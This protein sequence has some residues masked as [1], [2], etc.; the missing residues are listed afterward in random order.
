MRVV[1]LT[2]L[3]DKP[4]YDVFPLRVFSDDL[5]RLGID[6]VFSHSIWERAVSEADVVFVSSYKAKDLLGRGRQGG[7]A[8]EV[9]ERLGERKGKVIWFDSSDAADISQPYVLPNVAIY[10]KAQ[11]W[12]DRQLY[13]KPLYQGQWFKD[14]YHR[15]FGVDE[16]GGEL[17]EPPAPSALEKLALAWNPAFNDWSIVGRG[18]ITR[19]WHILF[20]VPHY[21]IARQVLPLK[22]RPL[23]ISCRVRA[24][25]KEPIVHFHREAI[26]NAVRNL[27]KRRSVRCEGTVSHARY[28]AEMARTRMVASPFGWGEICY[29][30]FECCMAGAVLLKP[31][32]SH[33]QTWPDFYVPEDTYVAHAWDLADF[34][35]KVDRVLQRVEESQGIADRGRTRLLD[36]LCSSA[37]GRKF[38]ERFAGL[39]DRALRS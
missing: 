23:D 29:R 39:V 36:A 18:R 13:S 38:A 33:L 28:L 24:W 30:D 14:Y 2:A 32:M 25:P 12:K 31:D 10:A 26:Q 5:R 21:R 20:P 4:H 6:V 9:A 34:E 1:T 16:P 22:E 8:R 27:G 35:S 7:G 3:H 19:G 17:R 15:T 37:A 11:I